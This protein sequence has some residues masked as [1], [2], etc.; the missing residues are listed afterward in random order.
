M[1]TAGNAPDISVHPK[2]LHVCLG[3]KLSRTHL[4]K[5]C[6]TALK[7]ATFL[8]SGLLSLI[9]EAVHQDETIPSQSPFTNFWQ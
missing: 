5:D 2:G 6:H 1:Q 3:M 9:K 4:E 8:A 7:K